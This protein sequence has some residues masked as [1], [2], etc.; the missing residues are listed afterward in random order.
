MKRLPNGK[1]DKIVLRLVFTF[2]FFLHQHYGTVR[3]RQIVCLCQVLH[4]FTFVILHNIV[5]VAR[6]IDMQRNEPIEIA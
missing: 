6:A 2:F 3:T 1:S 4:F 5:M